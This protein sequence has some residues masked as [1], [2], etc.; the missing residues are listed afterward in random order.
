LAGSTIETAIRSSRWRFLYFWRPVVWLKSRCSPSQ[1]NQTGFVTQ[2]VPQ[3]WSYQTVVRNSEQYR[4]Q[5][6]GGAAPLDRPGRRD[7]GP[8]RGLTRWLRPTVWVTVQVFAAL[9]TVRAADAWVVRL[10]LALQIV[11]IAG[12]AVATGLRGA[13]EL[14]ANQLRGR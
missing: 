1:P 4:T 6:T 9:G 2:S 12:L 10:D 7:D 3:S 13:A 11:V 8:R 14:R 5:S